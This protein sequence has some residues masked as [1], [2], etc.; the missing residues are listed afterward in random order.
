MKTPLPIRDG[1]APSY[2]WL[3]P[4]PWPQLRDF[5]RERFPEVAAAT[6]QDR[7][8][9]GEVVD[10][11]GVRLSPDSRYRPGIRIFYYRELEGE[12]PIPFE[13]QI[14]HRDAHI[15]VVDKPH[16]LPVIPSGR[17]LHET[18][19]VR[20]KKKLQLPDLTPIHRLDRET[21]G[22]I[23][24]S[25]NA[26]SRGAYQ[27]LFQ[28]RAVHKVYEALAPTLHGRTFPF[29]YRSRMVDGTPFF[30]M[31]E[32]AGEANSETQIDLIEQRGAL[33][34]YRLQPVTGRKHQ[35]RVH[36]AAL[37]IAIVNDAFYPDLRACKADDMTQPLQLLARAIAFIDP[38]D[39]SRRHFESLRT[40]SP[41]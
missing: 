21:A 19:L 31:Q 37:G 7:M 13:E 39:G 33:S 28:K 14:L 23:I 34:L 36:L 27:S 24:F 35:L 9:R 30:R 6:W 15:L 8:A 38:I 12:T 29:T 3:Q 18:L 17:F 26:A 40:L 4:G 41:I 32:V 2:V 25:H 20:L 5:L 16:F 22:V 10:G 11:D 1:V